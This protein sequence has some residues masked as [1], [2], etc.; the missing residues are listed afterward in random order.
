MKKTGKSYNKPNGIS[1][2]RKDRKSGT[3][4]SGSPKKRGH[5]G[6]FTW[7]GDGYSQPEIGFESGGVFDVKDPNFEDP[8]ESFTV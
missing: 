3:G 6:K 5:G 8:D 1:D 2:E 7:V 4:M